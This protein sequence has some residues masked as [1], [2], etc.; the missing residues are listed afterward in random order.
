MPQ[1]SPEPD[2]IALKIIKTGLQVILKN[3]CCPDL[4]TI[5]SRDDSDFVT[6]V[7]QKKKKK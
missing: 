3:P 2:S 5:S 4:F 1:N 6:Y 7:M